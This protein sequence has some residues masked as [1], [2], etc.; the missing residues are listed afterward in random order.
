[1]DIDDSLPETFS[2]DHL[3]KLGLYKKV[4]K[5]FIISSELQSCDIPDQVTQ[6]KILKDWCLNS[7]IHDKKQL[8]DWLDQNFLN[9][10]ELQDLI[11]KKWLWNK[12]CLEK[13]KNQISDYYFERKKSLDKVTYSLCRVKEEG[14]ALELFLRIKENEASFHD[15]AL[16][17]SEG[18][19][20]KLGG[21]IGPVE[22]GVPHP[23]ISKLLQESDQNKLLAPRKIDNWWVLL[24]LEKLESTGLNSDVSQKLSLE[25]GELY[26]NKAIKDF[27]KKKL[28]L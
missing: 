23:K 17:Y 12:W 28:L 10:Q 7:G 26:L 16:K 14:L 5:E 6:N 11:N 15:V 24:R 27:Y 19:E 2:T 3:V 9:Q 20:R 21:L 18:P 22:L 1:M 8:F 4:C 25:L 13:F